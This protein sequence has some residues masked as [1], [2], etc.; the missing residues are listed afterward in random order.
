MKIKMLIY[1]LNQ[2]CNVELQQTYCLSESA[3]FNVNSNVP[4]RIAYLLK[5]ICIM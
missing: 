2:L 5:V 4:N 1:Y 3:N